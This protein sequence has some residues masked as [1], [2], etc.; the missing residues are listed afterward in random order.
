MSAIDDGLVDQKLLDSGTELTSISEAKKEN[1]TYW[2]GFLIT[3]PVFMGYAC[4][5]SLQRNLSFVFGLTEGVSGTKTS[6]LF[7]LACSFVYLF[8]LI[9]RVLGHNI[10]FGC[11]HPKDRVIA[12]LSSTII[13]MIL[14]SIIS[15]QKPKQNVVWVF[16][17]YAFVGV[18]EGSY[19]PNMLNI[20]NDLGNTRLYVVLAMPTGVALITL[21]AF[22]LMA[23]GVPFQYFYI[24]TA[25]LAGLAIIL[26]LF[27]IY[28][29]V[30]RIAAE[31]HHAEFNLSDF[32]NDCKHIKEWFP[33]IWVHSLIFFVNMICLGLFNPGCTL[34]AYQSRV[35][36]QLFGGVTISHD[37]FLCLYNLGG[38]LGD[39]ISRKVMNNKRIIHPIFYFFLLLFG[40]AINI[41][42]IPEIAPFA[43]F[44]FMWANGGLYVQSTKLI[45]E[46]FREKYHLT[47]TS[48]WLFIGD[49]G[50]F[51]GSNL[52]QLVRPSI[53]KLRAMM[54]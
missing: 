40:F 43:A 20:V 39:Y 36:L 13:G 44:S 4:C 47:A 21:G 18:C 31:N 53:A 7:G 42:L 32:W 8:N 12:A 38:F 9:F 16:I 10:V 41:S 46:I 33:K 45:G 50:S 27:T 52:V 5:F 37:L 24:T 22:G 15:F 54:Y 19:G 28:P 23:L 3:L 49:G 26:Y 2:V 35:T 51:L 11:L 6:Y 14:L 30:K 1:K 17:T 48:T 34:Y 25:V 29:A